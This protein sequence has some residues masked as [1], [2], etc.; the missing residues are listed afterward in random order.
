MVIMAIW[1]YPELPDQIPSHFDWK[2]DPNGWSQKAFLFAFP[3][4]S[5]VLFSMMSWLS[6]K[7][8]WYNYPV[9]ITPENKAD[10]HLWGQTL[11]SHLSVG[12]VWAFVLL[13][14]GIIRAALVADRGLP[15]WMMPLVLAGVFAP[16][17]QALRNRPHNA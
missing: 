7:P 8:E 5:A 16:I 15:I 17:F 12:L 10:W 3:A 1:V 9:M 13:E 11:V 4:L 6:Q 14:Y 2:G